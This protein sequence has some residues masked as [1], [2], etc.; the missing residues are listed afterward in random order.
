MAFAWPICTCPLSCP[1]ANLEL[2][3]WPTTGFAWLLYFIAWIIHALIVTLL[4]SIQFLFSKFG[5]WLEADSH[6]KNCMHCLKYPVCYLHSLSS[7]L[8]TC[9][10]ITVLMVQFLVDQQF[11]T[12]IFETK[13]WHIN[14]PMA[15]YTVLLKYQLNILK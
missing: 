10:Y 11:L 12:I 14:Y 3:K 7:L 13:V 9:M 6:K 5:A 8:R 1:S 4:S 2:S 15:K